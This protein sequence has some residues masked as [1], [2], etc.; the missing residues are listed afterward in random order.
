[1]ISRIHIYIYIAPFRRIFLVLVSFWL[2]GF[3]RILLDVF[4]S[5]GTSVLLWR[6]YCLSWQDY[7]GF[8]HSPPISTT[9]IFV[10]TASFSNS[11][12]PSTDERLA[13][14]NQCSVGATL[15]SWRRVCD[16]PPKW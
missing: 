12:D 16:Q 11:Y 10:I 9:F 1:M 5:V 7:R 4:S 14:F 3:R 2:T 13:V 15:C 6:Y 8:L